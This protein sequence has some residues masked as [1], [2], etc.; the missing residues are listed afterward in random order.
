MA[1]ARALQQ[2]EMAE[3][4]DQL[5]LAQLYK[6]LRLLQKLSVVPIM[7]ATVLDLQRLLALRGQA[8]QQP[9]TQG[10]PSCLQHFKIRQHLHRPAILSA[11]AGD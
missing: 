10:S 11:A 6:A 1:S 9:I 5:R 8:V 2:R 7:L 3:P 4:A